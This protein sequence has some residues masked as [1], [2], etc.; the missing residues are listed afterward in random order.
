MK[1]RPLKNTGTTI[2]TYTILFCILMAG[3]FALFIAEGR[4]FVNQADA[5]DQGYFWTVEMKHHL[6]S[7]FAG[8]GY[9][10]WS[11]DRGTGLDTK[12]PIDP[13]LVISSF[14]P[15]GYVELGY[16]VAIILRLYFAGIAFILFGKEVRLSNFQSLVGA[17]CY[18]SATWTI[19]LSLMQGQFI[20]M[21]ILFPLLAMSVDRVCK[22]KSPAMFMLI[23]GITVGINYYLAY[24]AAIGIIIYI[25]FRYFTYNDF[26]FKS[27]MAYIGRFILYGVTGIM[28]GAVFVLV[29]IQ[30]LSGASTGA[31]PELEWLYS[32]SYYYGEG[33]RLVSQGYAFSYTNIGIP[34]FA[35]IALLAFRGKPTIKATHVI[36]SVIMLGMTMSPFFGS[37]FN[38]FGYVSNRWYFM[39]IFFLIWCAAEHMDLDDM[40][41]FRNIFVMLL[42]WGVLVVTTLGFSYKDITGDMT[43][44]QAMF[45]GGNLAAG[46]VMILIVASGRFLIR[47]LRARQALIVLSVI[48]TLIVVW[49]IS[50]PG[51]TDYYFRI[52]E[53]NRQLEESTQ[54]AGAFIDDS[55]FYRIDQADWINTHLN[56]DQPVNEN[57]WWQNNT[58]YLYDSKMPARLSEFNKLTGNNLGYSKR[59]YVQSNGNRMGLD[60]LYGVKY[61]LGDDVRNDRTGADGRAGYAFSL[62]DNLDGVNVFKSKYDSSLGFVY[63]KFMTE[64]EFGKLSR[65]EREQSLLQAVVVPDDEAEE[66]DETKR[67]TAADIETDIRDVPYEVAAQ[68]G[69]TL[70]G[71]TITADQDDA[72][73]TIWVEGVTDS[74]MVVS[75]DNLRRVN[76]AGESIGDFKVKCTNSKLKI[77]ANNKKN[78]Q[79]IPG[80]VDFDLNMGYYDNYSGYIRIYLSKAGRYEFDR[81]YVSAMS[82]ENFDKFAEERCKSVFNVA[83]RRSDLVSGTVDAQD[84]GWLFLSMP[85]ND[86][87]NVFIDGGQVA[88]IHNANI[89][90]FATPITRGEHQV[91]VR[92]DYTSRHIALGITSAG[93]VLMVILSLLARRR[94]KK[95]AALAEDAGTTVE[96]SGTPAENGEAAESTAASEAITEEVYH[97]K[98]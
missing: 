35:L 59:V 78:N 72:F 49:N 65:L 58:I 13:F 82:V 11:W 56:A 93:L 88:E 45:V 94:R 96:E 19:N 29:T 4:S 36:M 14:F 87:W 66:L 95:A 57:L 85:V 5:Y 3:I 48:G 43:K 60:F 1:I 91:E 17:L 68:D 54:R 7:L 23:V 70:D 20:D 10:V 16:T 9:P 30:T 73:L 51:R 27:Y 97:E 90:F 28:I 6:D 92:Y 79:T 8:D 25:F 15:A 22:G 50:F 77:D 12:L 52:G 18:I 86:N 47:S 89:A 69:L 40:A 98:H 41:K 84:D 32:T 55:G 67:V 46:F 64:S 2:L 24:M 81:L 76:D 39:L 74:Q 21:F 34:I 80:I 83:E 61:F 31:K 42:W 44:A 71:N 38:G 26:A 37:M 62:M 63:D 75:F 53:I 33:L